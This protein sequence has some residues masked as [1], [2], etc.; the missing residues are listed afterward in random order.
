MD[1]KQRGR[2]HHVTYVAPDPQ[3]YMIQLLAEGVRRRIIK[4]IKEASM[5][6][7]YQIFPKGDQM[8]IVCRYM[9]A[10]LPKKGLNLKNEESRIDEH[11][12]PKFLAACW[13]LIDTRYNA[14]LL[15]KTA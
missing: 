15:S 14:L 7:V 9:N 8:A 4:E 2:P 6:G 3:N 1:L 13:I 12:L 5:F 10:S 11:K